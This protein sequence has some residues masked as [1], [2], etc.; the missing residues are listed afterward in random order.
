MRQGGG[1]LPTLIPDDLVPALPMQVRSDFLMFLR[2]SMKSRM[3]YAVAAICFNLTPAMAAAPAGILGK[4]IHLS[5]GQ[6][7]P[8]ISAVGQ[9][10]HGARAVT[11]TI[12]VSS[13]GRIFAKVASRTGQ[14]SA[15]GAQNPENS[16][17]HFE[18]TKLVGVRQ[19]ETAAVRM[20]VSFDNNFQS[21]SVA[22]ILGTESGKPI[23]WTG[24]DGVKYTSTGHPIISAE[25]C[26]VA[27]GNGFAN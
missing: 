4:T 8:G 25:S 12:Y 23:V 10:V 26:S 18:G 20:A 2:T 22:V 17:F 3:A 24:L 19:T 27:N 16:I 7:V 14:F 5:W 21:C 9:T 13:A 1:G 15:A 6:S 11:L